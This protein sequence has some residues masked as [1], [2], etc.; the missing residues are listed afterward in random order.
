[1][2]NI[3]KELNNIKSR[4]TELG[5]LPTIER[6]ILLGQIRELYTMVLEAGTAKGDKGT[7]SFELETVTESSSKPEPE[8]ADNRSDNQDNILLTAGAGPGREEPPEEQEAFPE[9]DEKDIP[10]PTDGKSNKQKDKKPSQEILADKYHSGKSYINERLAHKNGTE[11][12]SSKLQSKPIKDIGGAI[13]INDKY[14]LIRDLFNGN[15]GIFE[16]TII[17]LNQASNFNEAFKYINSN[18]D[19]EMEDESVQLLLDLVRRK[20][21]VDKNG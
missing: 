14:K 10:L 18:F 13:G 8:P 3:L 12:L 17:Q 4:L 6:D 21:I 1:M 5:S 19:W 11:D 20:F 7:D 2:L 16:E 9:P 15:P